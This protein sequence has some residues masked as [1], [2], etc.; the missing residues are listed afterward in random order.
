M[1]RRANRRRRSG[2]G[3]PPYTGLLSWLLSLP[4]RLRVRWLVIVTVM[5][6]AMGA[7][8]R[9]MLTAPPMPRMSC[10]APRWCSATSRASMT[11]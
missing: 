10:R 6:V 3:G 9:V 4:A 2:G 1:N 7:Y 5:L 11:S 8:G